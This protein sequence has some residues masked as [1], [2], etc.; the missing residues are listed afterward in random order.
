M[1]CESPRAKA[2]RQTAAERT[3]LLEQANWARIQSLPT[4]AERS[5]MLSRIMGW[6]AHDHRFQRALS[7]KLEAWN[8][9]PAVSAATSGYRSSDAATG[10]GPRPGA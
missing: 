5:Y 4:E 10:H 9:P 7:L 8:F 3:A 1:N 2:P 6:F